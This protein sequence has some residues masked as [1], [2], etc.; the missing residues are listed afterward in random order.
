MP[1]DLPGIIRKTNKGTKPEEI[2]NHGGWLLAEFE[3]PEHFAL[4]AMMKSMWTY[5]LLAALGAVMVGNN[6]AC[7]TMHG[8]GRDTEKAGEG[9]QDAADKNK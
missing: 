3:C 4:E 7:N 6:L 5:L 2:A 8:I 9:L 1:A